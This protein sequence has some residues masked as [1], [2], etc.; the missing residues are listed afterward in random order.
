MALSSYT[1]LQTA[2][3]DWTA[4]FDSTVANRVPDFIRLGEERLWQRVRSQWGVESATLTVPAG[5][6]WVAL[7]TG[8]LAFKRIRSAAEPRM[9]YMSPDTL[10]DLPYDGDPTKYSIEGGRF[11]Y[12]QTP[13]VN[14][15]LTIKYFR[16]PGLLA[17][18]ATTWL[19]ERAPSIYLYAALIEAAIFVKNSDKVAEYGSL[20]DKAIDSFQSAD[21][22]AQISGSRLHQRRR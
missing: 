5:Q 7:P 4:R 21:L 3:K 22:A 8:W 1:D 6:N 16:H 20:L 12:G 19:L 17:T 10:E 14:L 2:V 13:S 9:E 11:L 15:D 18:V